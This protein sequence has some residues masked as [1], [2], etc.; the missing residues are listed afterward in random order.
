MQITEYLDIRREGRNFR[1]DRLNK[2]ATEATNVDDTRTIYIVLD[3]ELDT[4]VP[5]ELDSFG[6]GY[7]VKF[8]PSMISLRYSRSWHRGGWSNPDQTSVNLAGWHGNITVTGRQVKKDGKLGSRSYSK[9]WSVTEDELPDWLDT[10]D[11]IYSPVRGERFAEPDEHLFDQFQPERADM[12][13]LDYTIT[14]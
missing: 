11:L 3:P 13:T 7:D 2:E 8:R 9:T 12:P 6:Y 1:G 4:L 10:L 14:V 5:R